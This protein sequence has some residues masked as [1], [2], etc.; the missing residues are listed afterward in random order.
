MANIDAWLAFQAMPKS[1]QNEITQLT[2]LEIS[3]A[4]LSDRA[5]QFILEYYDE[6]KYRLKA[7]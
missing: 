7:E 1:T 5:K 4:E 3:Y 2:N 6:N